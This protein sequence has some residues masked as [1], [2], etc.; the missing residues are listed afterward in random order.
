MVNISVLDSSQLQVLAQCQRHGMVCSRWWTDLLLPLRKK[1]ALGTQIYVRC[2]SKRFN[3]K[4]VLI[5]RMSKTIAIQ[6]HAMWI[7]RLEGG[8]G[9][10]VE[11]RAFLW[12]EFNITE[13]FVGL[14]FT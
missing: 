5:L 11:V 13:L 14:G 7:W 6:I 3:G 1:Y 8:N 12:N 10:L 4:P 9:T 2:L